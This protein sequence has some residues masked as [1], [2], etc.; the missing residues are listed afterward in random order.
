MTAV[1]STTSPY[2]GTQTWGRFLDVWSGKTIAADV[3]DAVYQIDSPYDMRP[4]LLAYDMYKDSAY[5]W[6]FAVRNPDVLKDPLMDFKAGAI[7]YVP[8]KAT[9]TKSLGVR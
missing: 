2:Y 9:L 1:Y 5:W 4:D 8:T 6:V 3:T 7:I